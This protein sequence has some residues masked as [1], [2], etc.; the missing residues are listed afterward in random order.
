M[1]PDHEG[2]EFLRSRLDLDLSAVPCGLSPSAVHRK[3]SFAVSSSR[4]LCA[5]SRVLT[6]FDLP[7]VHPKL[8][9]GHLRCRGAPPLRF[10]PS[11]RRHRRRPLIPRVLFPRF[12]SVLDVSHVLDG[13]LRH[14]LC[15]LVSSRCHVQGLPS[16]GLIPLHGA[17]PGFPGRIMPSCRWTNSA[18]GLTRASTTRPRLQGLAPRGE[19]GAQRDRLKPR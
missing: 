7:L 6:T 2:A 15:R 18:C 5:S 11:S 10:V 19:F 16:R 3:L 13:L 1:R 9:C 4:E 17:V 8:P 12:C 14:Q